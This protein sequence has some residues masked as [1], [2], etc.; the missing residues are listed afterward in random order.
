MWE[1]EQHNQHFK[2]LLVTGFINQIPLIIANLT[3]PIVEQPVPPQ[4]PK[5]QN[6]PNANKTKRKLDILEF[7]SAGFINVF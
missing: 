3:M 7:F 6:V 2:Q 5:I 1:Y 4:R